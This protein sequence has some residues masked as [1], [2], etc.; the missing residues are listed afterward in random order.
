MKLNGHALTK[1]ELFPNQ[2][3]KTIQKVLVTTEGASDTLI[4]RHYFDQ[5]ITLDDL[6]KADS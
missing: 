4:A 6:F 2:K 5:V 3:R 1:I